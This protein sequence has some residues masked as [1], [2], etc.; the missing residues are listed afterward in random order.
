MFFLFFSLYSQSPLCSLRCLKKKTTLRRPTAAESSEG[1][2][3][4]T[5]LW[6][7]CTSFDS[8]PCSQRL[9]QQQSAVSS[10]GAQRTHD[11]PQAA[12]NVRMQLP[13]ISPQSYTTV[14]RESAG[15]EPGAW[16]S[17]GVSGPTR[18]VLLSM[19]SSLSWEHGTGSGT[20]PEALGISACSPSTMAF[21]W[22]GTME[23]PLCPEGNGTERRWIQDDT[24][25]MYMR[26]MNL[27]QCLPRS[28]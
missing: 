25:D 23:T 24:E 15:M 12:G 19:E 5:S 16:P 26:C 27:D 1:G 17:V 6:Y 10:P 2:N 21:I 11:L 22:L 20:G 8:P 13:A 7:V 14:L 4:H 3:P 28:T 9:D 18:R